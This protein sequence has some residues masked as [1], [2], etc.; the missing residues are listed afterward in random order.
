MATPSEA[1]P[2]RATTKPTPEQILANTE[3]LFK[4]TP[5]EFVW[6]VESVYLKQSQRACVVLEQI[7]FPDIARAFMSGHFEAHV[8]D[9]SQK[10]SKE[11][12]IL[13]IEVEG[14]IARVVLDPKEVSYLRKLV[15]QYYKAPVAYLSDKLTF[16]VIKKKNTTRSSC[17]Q[18]Y[19]PTKICK[20]ENSLET[21]K[22]RRIYSRIAT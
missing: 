17:R 10:I 21:A 11:D 15:Y 5:L 8:A 13:R 19:T 14:Q 1:R 9:D 16:P 2:T 3:K 20:Q 18:N 22:N 7:P 6:L 12:I 4:G